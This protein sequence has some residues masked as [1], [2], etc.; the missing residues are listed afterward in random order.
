MNNNTTPE[1]RLNAP[2]GYIKKHEAAKIMGCAPRTIDNWMKSGQIPYYKFGR[3]VL[4]KESELME[5]IE[6]S[7]V[8]NRP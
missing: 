3:A 6:K 8:T 7:K 5:A 2:M 1:Q 4:L